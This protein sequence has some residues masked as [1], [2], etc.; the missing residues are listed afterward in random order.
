VVCGLDAPLAEGPDGKRKTDG[1]RAAF[2]FFKEHGYRSPLIDGTG[3]LNTMLKD[4]KNRKKYTDIIAE[5]LGIAKEEGFDPMGFFPVDEPHAP[6]VQ[7]LAKIACTWTKDVK[8][9]NTYITMNPEAVKVLDPV[10]DYVCYNLS[11]LNEATIKSIKPQQKLMF[12]CPSFD[13]NPEPN[14][15]VSGFYMFKIGAFSSQ[16]YAYGETTDDPFCDL[17]GGNRDWTVVY[18]SLDSPFHDPT[19]EWESMRDGVYDYEF[20]YTLQAA[21]DLARKAGKSGE[22]DKA[23]KV[24]GE[25]LAGVDPDG[26][27]AGGPAIAIEADVRLKDK[28]LDPKLLAQTKALIGSAWYEQSRRKIAQAIIDLKTSMV[29]E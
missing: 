3:N 24:L 8:G 1:P 15:Y 26:N 10:L 14:R 27:R 16:Y 25:V 5:T 22:A 2:K 19:M 11:Y 21:A 7:A 28:Q 12:Y 9:A 4:E 23:M 17:D 20:C 13:V 6:E 29:A 18:P